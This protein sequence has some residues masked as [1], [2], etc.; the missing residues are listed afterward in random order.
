MLLP[1]LT[2]QE[3]ND[4]LKKRRVDFWNVVH[5]MEHRSDV[6]LGI[7]KS[8]P[9]KLPALS[10]PASATLA[11]FGWPTRSRLGMATV[12][13][14]LVE[15]NPD[16]LGTGTSDDVVMARRSLPHTMFS[17]LEKRFSHRPRLQ[18]QED[19]WWFLDNKPIPSHPPTRHEG[20]ALLPDPHET[21]VRR[22][23]MDSLLLVEIDDYWRVLSE[24]ALRVYDVGAGLEDGRPVQFAQWK[25]RRRLVWNVQPAA[26]I[27]L[28]TVRSRF[29]AEAARRA[30]PHAL[31]IVVS[32]T[33]HP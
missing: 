3:A 22:T 17:E 10:F 11:V 2:P 32:C 6:R 5:A 19:G 18:D 30:V 27:S 12:P 14:A 25:D 21:N 28:K 23:R 24:R 8:R 13:L 9:P 33:R 4:P 16:L 20:L 1:E 26:P 31:S 7:W 15:R 29:G